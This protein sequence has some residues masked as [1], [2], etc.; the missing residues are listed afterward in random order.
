MLLTPAIRVTRLALVQPKARDL[1]VTF[2]DIHFLTLGD[3]L[4]I[5]LLVK[6]LRHKKLRKF[7]ELD[8]GTVINDGA[9]R[10]SFVF[11][12]PSTD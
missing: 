12:I 1:F 8:F 7:K 9:K 10:A 4:A 2:K 5:S 6:T 3:K 11:Y